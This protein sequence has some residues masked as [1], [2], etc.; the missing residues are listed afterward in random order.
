M[1]A[2]V[3]WWRHYD[4]TDVTLNVRIRLKYDLHENVNN[5]LTTKDFFILFSLNVRQRIGLSKNIHDHT[6]KPKH[7][8]EK[9]VQNSVYFKRPELFGNP[10]IFRLFRILFNIINILSKFKSNSYYTLKEEI[11]AGRK[12]GEFGGFRKNPP[13]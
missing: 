8:A 12:F 3:F 6:Q 2:S 4:V 7:S 9:P 1:A 10:K 13:N 11:L 5:F